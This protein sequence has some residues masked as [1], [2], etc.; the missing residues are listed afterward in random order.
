MTRPNY[1]TDDELI[2]EL[3]LRHPIRPPWDTLSNPLLA[4]I[5]KAQAE[6]GRIID[7]NLAR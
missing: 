3:A 5:E 4:K 1:F 2:E 7:A 6:A